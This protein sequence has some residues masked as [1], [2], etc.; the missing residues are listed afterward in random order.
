MA[1]SNEVIQI[2]PTWICVFCQQPPHHRGMGDLFGPYHV[3][4]DNKQN[5]ASSPTQSQSKI[6]SPPPKKL[7][8]KRK[9]SEV[10][11]A[12]E[13]VEQ[14]QEVWFHEDCIAWSSG[15]YLIGVRIKNVD[16]VVKEANETIC[17]TCK[18]KGANLGCIQ[19]NCP[20]RFHYLCAQ[21][22]NCDLDEDYFSL[23]CPDH[24]RK[25][26]PPSASQSKLSSS[27]V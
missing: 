13:S 22:Q 23:Y 9:S 2:D 27:P 24:R 14:Q 16:E 25:T 3:S 19:K 8:G 5:S 1:S 10:E 20:K 6:K 17:F 15:V 18:L 21:D 7:T 11:K 26:Q 12:Q 4:V